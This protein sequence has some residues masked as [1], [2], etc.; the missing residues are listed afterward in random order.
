MEIIHDK[1][2]NKFYLIMDGMESNVKYSMRD[3]KTIEY[4]RVYVPSEQR[5]KGQAAALAEAALNYAMQN[6][7]SVIPSCSYMESYISRNDKFKDL[8]K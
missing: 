2:Y 1:E 3:E 5:G 4:W 6:N 7:L 8:V